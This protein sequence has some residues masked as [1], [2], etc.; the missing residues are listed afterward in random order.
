MRLNF[1][2]LISNIQYCILKILTLI[3]SLERKHGAK[4]V[5]SLQSLHLYL[6]MEKYCQCHC[7]VRELKDDDMV[8]LRHFQHSQILLDHR[9]FTT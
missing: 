5:V 3:F 2:D 1:W 6:K 8:E 9:N 7:M 4:S